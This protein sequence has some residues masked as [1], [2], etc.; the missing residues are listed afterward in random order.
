MGAYKD[1]VRKA[2]NDYCHH[3]DLYRL[4]MGLCDIADTQVKYDWQ[5]KRLNLVI[6]EEM[7]SRGLIQ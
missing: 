3:Q 7:T 2:F 6:K 4:I 1:Y 5:R